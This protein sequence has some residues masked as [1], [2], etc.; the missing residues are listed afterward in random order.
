MSG[1]APAA[2]LST[3][4]EPVPSVDSRATALLA[5]VWPVEKLMAVAGGGIPLPGNRL[6]KP[7]AAGAVTA[8]FTETARAVDGTPQVPVRVKARRGDRWRAGA[9]SRPARLPGSTSPP[10]G[11]G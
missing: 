3:P 4:S 5:R 11:T 1:R 7:A 2:P 6:R 10:G 9:P 8:T